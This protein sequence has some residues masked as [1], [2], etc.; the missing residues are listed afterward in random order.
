MCGELA[1]VLGSRV[2]EDDSLAGEACEAD[3]RHHGQRLAVP[4]HLLDRAQRGLRPGAVVRAERDY[5]ECRQPLGRLAGRY[6]AEGQRV[7][8]EGEER[9]DREGG[10]GADGVDRHR[11]LVE[12]EERLDGEEIDSPALEEPCL[13]GEHRG[14]VVSVLARVAER[15]DRARDEHVAAGHLP[16]VARDL[17]GRLVD[18]AD[19]VL[20]VA[21]AELSPVR[22]ERVR[23]DQLRAGADEPEVEG[24]HAL[25]RTQI[26]LLGAAQPRNGA[27][28][29]D[30][31]SAV[32]DDGR[33]G[34]EP[35]EEPSRHPGP[36]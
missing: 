33:A 15:P 3:V 25:R 1:E 10:H 24:E 28:D 29:E 9:D 13:L 26:R 19:V 2:R 27:R 14:L 12:V 32:R 11:E 7:L 22:P 5:V 20:E 16:R 4:T 35:R 23:L 6:A 17:R 30:S 8:V 36:L 18:R 34:C 31:H 21:L